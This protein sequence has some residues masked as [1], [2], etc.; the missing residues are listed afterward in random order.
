MY[1]T[2]LYCTVLYCTV[3]YCTV[4]YCTVL[5]CTVLYCTVLYCTVLYCTGGVWKFVG[6]RVRG[7]TQHREGRRSALC[8]PCVVAEA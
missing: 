4:L 7:R 2:V 1:C 8:R 6:Q 5:Y 3:L